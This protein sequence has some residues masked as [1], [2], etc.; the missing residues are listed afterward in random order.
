[1]PQSRRGTVH[2]AHFYKLTQT[3]LAGDSEKERIAII[4]DAFAKKE[5]PPLEPVAMGYMMSKDS[6][7]SDTA[8]A[9]LSHVM[10]YYPTRKVD[11]EWGGFAACSSWD[12]SILVF[13]PGS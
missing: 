4:Q 12:Y 11:S 3:A 8:P 13:R 10:F 1:M 6:H 9:N 7:L 2:P 5:L